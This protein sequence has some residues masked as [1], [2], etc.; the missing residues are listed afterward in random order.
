[1]F[2]PHAE[3]YALY[4][5]KHFHTYGLGGIGRRRERTRRQRVRLDADIED[6]RD[7]RARVPVRRPRQP[8]KVLIFQTRRP[9]VG[10]QSRVRSVPP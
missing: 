7:Y 3:G 4:M 5:A 9:P 1:M 6:A 2:A 10:W 8:P